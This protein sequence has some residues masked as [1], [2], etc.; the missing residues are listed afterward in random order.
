M[1]VLNL[2]LGSK[3]PQINSA[4]SVD[5]SALIIAHFLQYNPPLLRQMAGQNRAKFLNMFNYISKIVP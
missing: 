5:N 3:R 4:I 2:R 1:G